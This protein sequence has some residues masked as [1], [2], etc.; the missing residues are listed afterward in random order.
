MHEIWNSSSLSKWSVECYT[1]SVLCVSVQVLIGVSLGHASHTIPMCDGKTGYKVFYFL[2]NTE[3]MSTLSLPF[4]CVPQTPSATTR[5][6]YT[7]KAHDTLGALSAR[8][9][10]ICL[11]NLPRTRLVKA[12]T[13]AISCYWVVWKTPSFFIY[14]Y[15]HSLNVTVSDTETTNTKLSEK[16]PPFGVQRTRSEVASNMSEVT[17]QNMHPLPRDRRK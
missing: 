8:I 12:A 17:L 14:I 3:L 1:N 13:H 2:W 9:H 7:N 11:T 10:N 4:S 5:L 15:R 6:Q 16:E